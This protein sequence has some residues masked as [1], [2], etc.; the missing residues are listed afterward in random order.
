ML[1]I[2]ISEET[3]RLI[4]LVTNLLNMSRLESGVWH[5]EKELCYIQ[6]I[7]NKVLERQKW[8]GKQYVYETRFEPDLPAIYADKNQ[9]EQVITNLLENAA[10]Y[11]EEGSSITISAVIEKR[12][13]KITVSD[14]G[15]GIPPEDLEKI[16][17]KFYRGDRDR[18]RPGGTG[19]GLAICKTIIDRH[20][21]KIW[22]EST[23]GE[24]TDIHFTLPAARPVDIR[25]NAKKN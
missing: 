24:G 6:D 8:A 2:G 21:G 17:D 23:A 12:M 5:P 19:L 7:V 13:L 3:E 10:A 16:F 1:L 14:T 11:S 25:N 4:S 22:A 9:I 20:N 18:Q 15:A